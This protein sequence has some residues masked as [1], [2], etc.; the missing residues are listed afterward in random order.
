MVEDLEKYKI[1]SVR[2]KTLKEER[3][4]FSYDKERVRKINKEINELNYYQQKVKN[5]LLILKENEREIIHKR[6][7]DLDYQFKSSYRL[8]QDLYTSYSLLRAQYNSAIKKLEDLDTGR[9]L[10]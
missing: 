4:V 8:A 7:M 3:N 9:G 10:H 2:I 6:Y 5:G 1:R